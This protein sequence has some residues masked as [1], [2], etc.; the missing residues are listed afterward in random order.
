MFELPCWAKRTFR[1]E[2]IY[3]NIHDNFTNVLVLKERRTAAL[4]QP[5][6]SLNR[7]FPSI[8]HMNSYWRLPRKPDQ[9]VDG[10]QAP[11]FSSFFPSLQ[12]TTQTNVKTAASQQF[13]APTAQPGPSIETFKLRRRSDAIFRISERSLE[14]LHKGG[15]Q[16]T[17]GR[18][19]CAPRWRRCWPVMTAL[20]LLQMRVWGIQVHSWRGGLVDHLQATDDGYRDTGTQHGSVLPGDT[21]RSLNL[22]LVALVCSFQ[23]HTGKYEAT[24][25][26]T[27]SYCLL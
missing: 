26:E 11:K 23:W 18:S 21:F 8:Y 17:A 25:V 24:S 12:T 27:Q 20:W 19:A 4:I 10:H 13:R 16:R 22:A 5:P 7:Q 2:R 3:E 15:H 6:R 1:Y 9:S 14:T